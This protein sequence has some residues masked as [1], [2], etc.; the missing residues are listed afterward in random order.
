MIPLGHDSLT[1]KAQ[2]V[3]KLCNLI[4]CNLILFNILSDQEVLAHVLIGH[5]NQCRYCGLFWTCYLSGSL[6]SGT[7]SDFK[8]SRVSVSH[9]G[10]TSLCKC[11][12]TN[13]HCS[14]TRLR[15]IKTN[16][17]QTPKLASVVK[18]VWAGVFGLGFELWSV[19]ACGCLYEGGMCEY[20]YFRATQPTRVYMF[21]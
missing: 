21:L 19:W 17:I 3:R 20:V 9:Q 15:P 11:K 10:K 16:Q 8:N 12:T 13:D 18:W 1:V 5:H 6:G 4:V 2:F 14:D 7:S